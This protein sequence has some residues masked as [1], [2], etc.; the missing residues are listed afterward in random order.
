MKHKKLKKHKKW[1]EVRP[2]ALIEYLLVP[3]LTALSAIATLATVADEAWAYALGLAVATLALLL[4]PLAIG[5]IKL[6]QAFAPLSLRRR[7][8]YVPSCSAYTLACIRRFGLLLGMVLGLRRIW[9]CRPP[10][11]GEDEPP[12]SLRLSKKKNI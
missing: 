4:R 12:L 6:Y 9:R 7:C 8:R 2:F 5:L 11:G 1:R 3:L 10:H